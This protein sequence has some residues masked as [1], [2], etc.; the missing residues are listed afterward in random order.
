MTD[1]LESLRLKQGFSQKDIAN[2]LHVTIPTISSWELNKSR[3]RPKFIP[4]LAEVLNTSAD[5]I[6]L[7][8]NTKK[9][10]KK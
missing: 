5:N 4:L 10:S 2:K 8:T 6:I 7:L 3:P 9:V 1:T